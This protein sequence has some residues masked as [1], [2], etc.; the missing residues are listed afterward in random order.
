MTW[1][2]WTLL[3]WPLAACLLGLVGG[4]LLR[5]ATAV[6][7]AVGEEQ[8][9]PVPT[10]WRGSRTVAFADNTAEAHLVG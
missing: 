1:L 7:T 5:R 2:L 8:A 4:P 9:P 3:C 6:R 10:P